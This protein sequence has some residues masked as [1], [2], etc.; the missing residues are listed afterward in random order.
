MA[1]QK[2]MVGQIN[3]EVLAFTTGK[4]PIL[5]LVLAEADCL[6]SAAHVTMLANLDIDPPLFT[7]R[8]RDRIVKELIAIIRK[9]RSGS[10]EIMLADQDV[11][12]AV[13]RNLTEKLGDIG[14]RNR[15]LVRSGG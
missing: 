9:V 2:T 14:K 13:E 6:G 1:T 12:L 8:D 7:G 11:H 4:D 10:F 15:V 3:P 5:D